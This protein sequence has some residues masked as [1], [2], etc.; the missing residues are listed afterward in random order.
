MTVLAYNPLAGTFFDPNDPGGDPITPGSNDNVLFPAGQYTFVAP[1]GFTCSNMFL[2]D[3]MRVVVPSG[4]TVSAT[5]IISD[6]EM[7]SLALGDGSGSASAVLNGFVSIG[8]TA[9][10]DVQGS[11]FI[12]DGLG[13]GGTL[14]VP[15][16]S[17]LHVGGTFSALLSSAKVQLSG[18]LTL[19]AAVDAGVLSNL[20]IDTGHIVLSGATTLGGATANLATLAQ[21]VSLAAPATISGGTVNLGA[22]VDYASATLANDTINGT[23]NVAAGQSVTLQDG[24]PGAATINVTGPLFNLVNVTDLTSHILNIGG[25]NTT[26]EVQ[27]SQTGSG[28]ALGEVNFA[29][30]AVYTDG[31]GASVL[32]IVGPVKLQSSNIPYTVE[33]H[34]FRIETPNSDS[35]TV[36]SGGTLKISALTNDT[37]LW[38]VAGGALL[39]NTSGV[40]NYGQ[41][42]FLPAVQAVPAVPGGTIEFNAANVNATIVDF[43]SADSIDILKN[44]GS[45]TYHL[46]LDSNVLGVLDQFDD[47]LGH[48]TLVSTRGVTYSLDQFNVTGDNGSGALITAPGIAAPSC[49]VAGTLISTAHGDIPVERLRIGDLV[50]THS[51]EL[52]PIRRIGYRQLDLT[53]HVHPQQAC[54]IRIRCDAFADGVPRRDLLLSPDHAVFADGALIPIKYLVN[55]ATVVQEVALRMVS[56]FHV[57]LAS[58]D[59]LLAEGLPAESYLDSGTNWLFANTP[60]PLALHPVFAHWSWEAL[61]CA[62]LVV[63]GPRLEKHR[64]QLAERAVWLGSKNALRSSRRAMGA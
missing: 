13:L 45:T 17:N 56:Y 61:A 57:E 12:S 5:V 41:I 28:L 21:Q 50:R 26:V 6:G 30:N 14:F 35:V 44:L 33:L 24:A 8:D 32:S 34:V 37:N 7:A 58:H 23:M 20:S 63:T 60:D 25:P 27:A 62:P 9:E 18:T 53:R 55:A 11:G 47:P 19:E 42:T 49:F 38:N 1:N 40:P 36:D 15:S 4:A 48:F 10:L 59:I 16:D 22:N 29:G 54:P 51:G 52:R 46:T 31:T 64:G 43:S 39:F 3:G 2:H